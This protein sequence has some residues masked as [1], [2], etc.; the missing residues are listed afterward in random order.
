MTA[1]SAPTGRHPV[2]SLRA[3]TGYQRVYV[4]FVEVVHQ[5]CKEGEL[6]VAFFELTELAAH[7]PTA[8]RA[9]QHLL[10]HTRMHFGLLGLMMC[11]ER[12]HECD[13]IPD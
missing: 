2:L 3:R 7:R 9:E 6:S 12:S 1:L 13:Y 11:A 10:S 8:Q 5:L 4:L